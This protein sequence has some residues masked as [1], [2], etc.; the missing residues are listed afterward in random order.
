M[1]APLV[2]LVALFAGGVLRTSVEILARYESHHIGIPSMPADPT[3]LF[4]QPS[5]LS[6]LETW[7]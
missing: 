2:P 6:C 4:G 7:F 3:Q 5:I 1:F